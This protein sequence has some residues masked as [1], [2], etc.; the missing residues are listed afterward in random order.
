MRKIK[1]CVIFLVVIAL[2]FC[3]TACGNKQESVT[4]KTVK[5][6]KATTGMSFP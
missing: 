4:P 6:G 2:C 1:S 3:F 5:N